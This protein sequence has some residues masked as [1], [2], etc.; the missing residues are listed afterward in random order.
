MYLLSILIQ[1]SDPRPAIRDR[2]RRRDARQKKPLPLIN[3]TR[4]SKKNKVRASVPA[5][6][7]K[8][9]AYA[10][11][12]A[13]AGAGAGCATD[14]KKETKMHPDPPSLAASDPPP[15]HQEPGRP[16]HLEV[17]RFAGVQILPAR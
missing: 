4:T 11:A 5:L 2:R 3:T 9:K 14:A 1:T 12:D 15:R 16:P 8:K 13:D 6:T 10:E 17:A 7:G